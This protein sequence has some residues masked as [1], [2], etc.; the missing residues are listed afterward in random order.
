[1]LKDEIDKAYFKLKSIGNSHV[2][3]RAVKIVN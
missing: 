3:A 2:S 1:M